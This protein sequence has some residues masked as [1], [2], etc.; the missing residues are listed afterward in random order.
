ML[1]AAVQYQA[2]ANEGAVLEVARWESLLLY[3]TQRGRLHALDLRTRGDAWCLTADPSQAS[4]PLKS[5]KTLDPNIY[6]N[7]ITHHSNQRPWHTKPRVP[8]PRL[9]LCSHS[10][11]VSRGDNANVM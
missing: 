10:A 3:S 9:L 5:S 6:P 8:N 11:F 2:S 4:R 1:C 7:L